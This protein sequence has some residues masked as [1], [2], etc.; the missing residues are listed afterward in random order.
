MN[1]KIISASIV[2]AVFFVAT[3]LLFMLN[4]SIMFPSRIIGLVFILYGEIVF[5]TGYILIEY[6]SGKSNGVMTWAGLGT[7]ILGYALIVCA[8]SLIYMKL[9]IF[10]YVGFVS[11]QIVLLVLCVVIS[12]FIAMASMSKK[13]NDERILGNQKVIL[14]FVAALQEMAD[15]STR[16]PELTKLAE[17]LRYTDTSCVVEVD[18]EIQESVE[19]VREL[20]A[21][22]QDED[23]ELLDA[24]L[25]TLRN[26]INKRNIQTRISKQGGL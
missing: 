12:L 25:K 26:L 18:T 9:H 20:A 8:S 14:E 2:G 16:G 4:Y 10:A 22:T 15:I 11:L 1:K 23:K 6:L 21:A 17:M 13:K 19:R 24:E 7:S 3:I 5:F